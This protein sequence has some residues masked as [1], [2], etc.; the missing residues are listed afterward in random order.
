MIHQEKTSSVINSDAVGKDNSQQVLKSPDVNL[1]SSALIYFF[2][3][4]I[5]MSHFRKFIIEESSV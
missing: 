1:S 2:L 5:N 3:L 4:V